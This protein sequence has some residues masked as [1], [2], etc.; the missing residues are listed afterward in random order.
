MTKLTEA[1]LAI[2]YDDNGVV[3]DSMYDAKTLLRKKGFHQT[4]E[5]SNAF[6]NSVGKLAYIYKV[7]DAC[8][9]PGTHFPKVEV[10]HYIPKGFLVS[11]GGEPRSCYEL[12]YTKIVR[13][14]I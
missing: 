8:L 13:P 4:A 10:A 6:K 2:A 9:K 12:K 14:A 7:R 11:F 1:M 3:V 5:F